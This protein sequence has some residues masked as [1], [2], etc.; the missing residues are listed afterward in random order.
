MIK[1]HILIEGYAHPGDGDSFVASPTTALIEVG[2][3][4]ILFDPG[5]N[6]DLLKT[7]LQKAHVD[8][9]DISFIYLS[10]YHPDHFLNLKL[11]PH[12]DVYDGEMI[13]SNDN[14]GFHKG[15]LGFEGIEILKT[16]GHSPEHTSLLID[17]DEGK[18]C[19]AQDVFW[20]EDGKQKSDNKDDLL[21]LVDPYAT[22]TEALRKSRELVLEKAD[23]IIPGHGKKFKNPTK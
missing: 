10:H 21:S 4:K 22:D 19:L 18:V 23:W 9:K 16:P 14:E 12:L 13:W 6:A 20:W 2:G 7:A 3:Q 11:F 17:T 5:A 1:I 8:S 15:S